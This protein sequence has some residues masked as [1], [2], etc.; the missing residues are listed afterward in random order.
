MRV[1]SITEKNL[2]KY[3]PGQILCPKF[4]NLIGWMLETLT[5][6]YSNITLVTVVMQHCMGPA[7]V[8]LSAFYGTHTLCYYL[9][10]TTCNY[11]VHVCTAGLS[12][13]FRPFV[14]LY[15]YICVYVWCDQKNVFHI[16]PVI[17]Y[18]KSLYNACC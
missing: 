9:Q 7:Y 18:R 13:W 3:V 12:V 10:G 6:C 5:S 4:D 17:I 1:V 16:L 8:V 2:Y 15:V 14:Y 11:P